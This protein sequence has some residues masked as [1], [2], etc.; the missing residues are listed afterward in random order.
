MPLR[1]SGS[2][3][4]SGSRRKSDDDRGGRGRSRSDRKSSDRSGDSAP[5]P[6]ASVTDVESV[7]DAFAL[8][9]R[10]LEALK[11]DKN[12]AEKGKTLFRTRARGRAGFAGCRF[13]AGN[14][15]KRP[16]RAL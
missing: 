10:S 13:H 8:L 14:T 6:E 4:R 15:G 3:G 1:F 9:A 2:S 5:A 12:Y 16:V 11:D 7:G